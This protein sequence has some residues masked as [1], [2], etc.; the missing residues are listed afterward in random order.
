MIKKIIFTGILV[1]AH[2]LYAETLETAPLFVFDTHLHYNAGHAHLYREEDIR[3]IFDQNN[4]SHAIITSNPPELALKLYK[5]APDI[6]TPFLGIYDEQHDKQDWFQD[7]E[8][9]NRINKALANRSWKGIGEIHLFA[10]QR[11]NPVFQ[12]IVQ[13]ANAHSLPLLMHSDPA[14]IDQIYDYA[15]EATVIWAH[16]GAYPYPPLLRD[17]LNR[18]SNLYIDLSMRNE[19]IAP[20]GILAPEWELLFMEYP[21][22]FMLGVDTFSTSRWQHYGEHVGETRHWLAQLPQ[23]IAHRISQQ[24]ASNLFCPSASGIAKKE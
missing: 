9:P 3:Q 4:I 5:T 7:A 23:D 12:Q 21:G 2:P 1:F 24:N 6:I 11:H 8:L 17:Y 20:G 16:A 19:R 10:E 22:R 13:L 14:I 15:P 18:Y